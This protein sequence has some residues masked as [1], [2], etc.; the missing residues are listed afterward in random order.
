MRQNTVQGIYSVA[1]FASL[2]SNQYKVA[3]GQV[4]EIDTRKF[5]KWAK[6]QV[7]IV[8]LLSCTREI[9][10]NFLCMA[11]TC[12]I[13]Y[14][15]RQSQR[16]MAEHSKLISK[17]LFAHSELSFYCDLCIFIFCSVQ[18]LIETSFMKLFIQKWVLRI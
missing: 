14:Y 4:F 13:T 1:C 3:L 15:F 9:P 11:E 6:F 17:Q 10:A 8:A 2:T 12:T 18:H 7:F 5:P 16:C